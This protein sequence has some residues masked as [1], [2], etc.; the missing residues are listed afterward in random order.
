[1]QLFS[2]F[3]PENMKKPPSKVAHNQPPTFFFKTGPAAQTAQ[4]QK[5]RTPKSPLLQDWV[6]RLG[7][8]LKNSA[9][10]CSS[11]KNPTGEVQENQQLFDVSYHCY[12]LSCPVGLLSE[13]QTAAEFLKNS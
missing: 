9:A 5:S 4:K 10:A 13:E 7:E 3:D 8:F 12:F 6:F 11:E 1:M 2:F